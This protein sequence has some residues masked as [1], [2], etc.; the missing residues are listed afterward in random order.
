MTP[1]ESVAFLFAPG[2]I[3]SHALPTLE[4]WRTVKLKN[5][6]YGFL[7]KIHEPCLTDLRIVSPIL[8]RT[9]ASLTKDFR[10]LKAQSPASHLKYSA[11]SSS[12]MSCC[13]LPNAGD[14]MGCSTSCS[15]VGGGTVLRAVPLTSGVTWE[16]TFTTGPYLLPYQKE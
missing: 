16:A 6:A 8:S 1:G 10:I 14:I 7:Y 2:W 15:F 5:G 13:Y 9:R 3:D 11:V 12:K 4:R